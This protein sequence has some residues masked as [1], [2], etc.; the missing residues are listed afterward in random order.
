MED[1][2][3]IIYDDGH[4]FEIT[5]D[6]VYVIHNLMQSGYPHDDMLLFKGKEIDFTVDFT[7]MEIR[8]KDA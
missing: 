6:P 3:I 4:Q 8:I 2:Y 5:T 1:S 7:N